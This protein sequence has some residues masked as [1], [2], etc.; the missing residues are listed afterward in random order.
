LPAFKV[1]DTVKKI[2]AISL[3]VFIA[4]GIG[5]INTFVD[6]TLASGLAEGSVA[7]LN[8]GMILVGLITGMTISI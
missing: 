4:S 2:V 7:A 1:N 5:Q 8:Y 3:P 6:K